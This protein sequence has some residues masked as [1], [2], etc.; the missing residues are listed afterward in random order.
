MQSYRNVISSYSRCFLRFDLISKWDF[1]P[2]N[3]SSYPGS[4][5]MSS[6]GKWLSVFPLYL[7]RMA[8]K[9]ISSYPCEKGAKRLLLAV[10]II[11]RFGVLFPE[12]MNFGDGGDS[13]L[14]EFP[15]VFVAVSRGSSLKWSLP[16]F[17]R[18]FSSF[19]S[20]IFL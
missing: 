6:T 18:L 15:C 13:L 9:R 4:G 17:K 14:L 19:N 11:Y 16:I 8:E 1:P 5:L 3:S 2:R 20:E 12:W 10:C 7:E